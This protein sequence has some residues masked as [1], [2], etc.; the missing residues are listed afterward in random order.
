MLGCKVCIENLQLMLQ[1]LLSGGLGGR[2]RL[3]CA[4]ICM[5]SRQAIPRPWLLHH[6]AA[7][8]STVPSCRLLQHV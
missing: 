5:S 8:V 2:W 6:H 7:A 4:L 1:F 3:C